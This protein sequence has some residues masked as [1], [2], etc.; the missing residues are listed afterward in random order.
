MAALPLPPGFDELSKADQILYLQSLWDQISQ[1][2]AELPI[3]E[4]HLKLAEARLKRHREDPS[5]AH[6]AFKIL[7]VLA[8]NSK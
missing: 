8:N 7:D 2:P 4:S 1:A 3:P 5:Q 6:S